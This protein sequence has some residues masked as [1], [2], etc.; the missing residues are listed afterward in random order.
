M[1]SQGSFKLQPINLPVDIPRMPD[2]PKLEE[3]LWNLSR[4][5]QDFNQSVAAVNFSIALTSVDGAILVNLPG[6]LPSVGLVP[7]GSL[8]GGVASGSLYLA[9]DQTWKSAVGPKGDKGDTG[10]PGTSYSTGFN[11]SSLSAG[12]LT[13]THNLAFKYSQVQIFD[14]N[15]KLIDPESVTLVDL[16]S[17]TADLSSHGVIAGTWHITVTAG[18]AMQTGDVLGPATNTNGFIPTWNGANSKTLS[19]GLDPSTLL[20]VND[21]FT[22]QMVG[23]FDEEEDE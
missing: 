19:N 14:N 8:G 3:W 16:N 15:D 10:A 21:F 2:N 13:V 9:G 5:V 12:I 18:G 22:Y 20:T 23:I 11:Y 7:T 6:I 4:S 17:L 1:T